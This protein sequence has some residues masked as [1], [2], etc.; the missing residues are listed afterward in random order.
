M[1][2]LPNHRK[3]SLGSTRPPPASYCPSARC[4]GSW[5]H[6]PPLQRQRKASRSQGAT[7]SPA[8]EG[9]AGGGREHSSRST[10]VLG[11]GALL[12]VHRLEGCRGQAKR[13]SEPL[14]PTQSPNLL[15]ELLLPPPPRDRQDSDP[16]AK[17]PIPAAGAAHLS[18][19]EADLDPDSAGLGLWDPSQQKPQASDSG[20]REVAEESAPHSAAASGALRLFSPQT[21]GPGRASQSTPR[22]PHFPG[23]K[24]EPRSE[25]SACNRLGT[26]WDVHSATA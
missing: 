15:S 24:T 23:G 9:T 19:Q 22:H 11:G 8:A 7:R 5:P 21:L 14:A 16:D 25:C 3:A 6:T 2:P 1:D 13:E 12:T 17:K 26:G 18:L 10:Q 4:R 20:E